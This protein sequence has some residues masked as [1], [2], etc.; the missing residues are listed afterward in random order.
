MECHQI[1]TETFGESPSSLFW[2]NGVCTA[3]LHRV[4]IEADVLH[5]DKFPLSFQ[6]MWQADG[7]VIRAGPVGIRDSYL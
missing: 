5:L 2:I 4:I 1:S 3:N 6:R 7:A